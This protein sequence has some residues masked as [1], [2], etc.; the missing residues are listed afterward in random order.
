VLQPPKPP[1]SQSFLYSSIPT[2][3]NCSMMGKQRQ[4]LQVSVT[5]GTAP[6]KLQAACQARIRQKKRR[7]TFRLD[8]P[9]VTHKA[10]NTALRQPRFAP[11]ARTMS[12]RRASRGTTPPP[13]GGTGVPC[14]LPLRDHSSTQSVLLCSCKQG[15][16]VA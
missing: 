6:C 11:R 15:L 5:V 1:N 16:I 2:R 12:R 13:R 14:V 9:G 3:L 8:P 4:S 10:V 7:G